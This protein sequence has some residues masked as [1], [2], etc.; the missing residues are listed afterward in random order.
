MLALVFTSLLGMVGVAVDLGFGYAHHR[1]VQSAAVAAAM[2]G[3][4]G[5]G[6]HYEYAE[7]V[8]IAGLTLTDYTDAMI[9]R[10][11]TTAAAASVPP[12]PA[13]ATLPAWPTGA[14]DMLTAYYL[15]T[16]AAGNITQGA[17]VGSGGIPAT[18]AVRR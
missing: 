17:Q 4:Q 10:D 8:G 15:L 14:G 12:F 18:A 5:L 16:A 13:P 9:L 3:A 6:R 1:Q 7:I 2:A 11:V